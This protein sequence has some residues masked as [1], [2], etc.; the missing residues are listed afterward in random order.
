MCDARIGANPTL[1]HLM[2]KSSK[3]ATRN[4]G[5]GRSDEGGDLTRWRRFSRVGSIQGEMTD[6][7]V[8]DSFNQWINRLT[9][10]MNE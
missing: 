5:E 7:R 4:G 9:R 3:L 8:I 1:D 2:I 10:S 6:R